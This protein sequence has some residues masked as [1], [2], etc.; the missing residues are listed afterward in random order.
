MLVVLSGSACSTDSR[1]EDERVSMARNSLDQHRYREAIIEMRNLLLE[2]KNNVDARLLLSYALLEVGDKETAQKE[3]Y[4]ARDLG[5]SPQQYLETLARSLQ[6][7]GNHVEVI[8]E[9]DPRDLD[10]TM[11]ASTL[12]AIRGWSMLEI[13]SQQKASDVFDEELALGVSLEAQRISLLGKARIAEASGEIEQAERFIG[14]ALQLVPGEAESLMALGRIYLSQAKYAKAIE[15]LAPA[16]KSVALEEREASF[17][18]EAQYAEALLGLE[19]L[20]EARESVAELQRLSDTHPM[21]LFLSG[22]VEFQSGHFAPAVE[23]F[24]QLLAEYPNY[25]PALTLMGVAMLQRE[26]VDQAEMFLTRAV[27]LD[28]RNVMAR[29]LLAE[30][31]LRMGRNSAAVRTLKDGLSR[32]DANA[33]LLSMLGRATMRGGKDDEGLKYL[34]TAYANAPD[35]PNAGVV[36]ASAYLSLGNSDEAVAV[37]KSIPAGVISESRRNVLI[38][39]ARLDNSDPVRAEKQIELLLEDVEPG[40]IYIRGLAGS[41]Y[42]A[43]GQSQKA[44]AMFDQILSES[45]GNRSAMLSILNLDEVAGDYTRSKAL[46]EA[47]HA[48]NQN[49]LLPV[50]VLARI[51]EASGEQ[52]QAIRLVIEANQRD[53]KALLPNLMLAA[54]ALSNGEY[55]A[56]E[57]FSTTAVEYYPRSARAFALHGLAKMNLGKLSEFKEA[58]ENAVVLD[59]DNVEYNY[60]LGKAAWSNGQV[61]VART[62][63]TKVVKSDTPYLPAMRA[64]ALLHTEI[65][66]TRQANELVDDIVARFGES[67]RA[68]VSVG[69]IRAAQ[70]LF[71][72]AESAFE[73]AWDLKPSWYVASEL[74]KLRKAYNLANPTRSLQAWKALAA[75]DVKPRLRIAQHYHEV[76]D[77]DA[78]VTEYEATLV[79]E[80]ESVITLNN[81]A[82]LYF[83]RGDE[84]DRARALE[85]ARKAYELADKSPL[86]ADTYGWLLFQ[87]DEVQKSRDVLR[88]AFLATTP[89]KSPDIA[90]HYAVVQQEKDGASGSAVEILGNALKSERPFASREKAQQLYEELM[91][92]LHLIEQERLLQEQ[93]DQD[94]RR[95]PATTG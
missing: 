33:E 29:R 75:E 82:W 40:D 47:A 31:R 30:T 54:N 72:Q 66:R 4:R 21:T 85:L 95:E 22:R 93:R 1:S 69:D 36:L 46:F 52:E 7:T 58:F 53:P 13:G 80:P 17:F 25:V 81:L 18:I 56:A 64:L 24:E 83:E 23:I 35:S 2:N 9:I 94:S 92:E 32:D 50:M 77:M 26:D 37:L 87:N 38:K 59:P 6:G 65:G 16:R 45:P 70:G 49:E 84:S 5:A 55:E 68:L 44:R 86:I 39:V 48:S 10:D 12:R 34:K 90:Y 78:A 43:T 27:A 62:S 67:R 91:G 76:G 15:L 42:A 63:F 79:V 19:R 71:E 61:L 3:A 73:S 20:D 57:E 88:A 28:S 14:Q 8:A 74:Y 89:E 11:L 51:Y 60:Y 41:F